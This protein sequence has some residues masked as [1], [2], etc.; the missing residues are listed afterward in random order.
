MAGNLGIGDLDGQKV[1]EGAYDAEQESF[2]GHK[3]RDELSL[4]KLGDPGNES[5]LYHWYEILE[6]QFS[7]ALCLPLFPRREG[8]P[9]CCA[10]RYGSVAANDYSFY[11]VVHRGMQKISVQKSALMRMCLTAGMFAVIAFGLFEQLGRTP[12]FSKSAEIAWL[13]KL[14]ARLPENCSSFCAVAGPVGRPVKYEYQIDAML[15]SIMRQVPTLNGYS[16]YVP[17]GWSLWEV[18]APGYEENVKKWINL[19]IN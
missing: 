4:F 13:N 8:F 10:L 14:A 1:C 18:E 5:L 9:G 12:A 16:G 11:L 2:G 17:L 6:R 7:V 15:V 3:L 19:Y